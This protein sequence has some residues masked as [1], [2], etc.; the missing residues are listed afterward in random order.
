MGNTAGVGPPAVVDGAEPVVDQLG[1][2]L[3]VGYLF[4]VRG[5]YVN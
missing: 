3:A 4:E 5:L 1:A 2:R